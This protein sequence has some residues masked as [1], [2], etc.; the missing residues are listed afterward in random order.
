MIGPRLITD[1]QGDRADSAMLVAAKQPVLQ[2]PCAKP[3]DNYFGSGRIN[4]KLIRFAG[5][6]VFLCRKALRGAALPTGLTVRLLGYQ[7]GN[8]CVMVKMAGSKMVCLKRGE[9]IAD[10]VSYYLPYS[11]SQKVWCV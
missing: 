6:I 8:P 2:A 10:Y 3:S 4:D 11:S 7:L 5:T 9:G 1:I